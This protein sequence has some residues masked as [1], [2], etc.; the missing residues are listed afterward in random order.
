[1]GIQK[2]INLGYKGKESVNK[3]QSDWEW[4]ERE[5]EPEAKNLAVDREEEK[6]E[7]EVS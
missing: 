6:I 1:M 7:N 3:D 4:E 5:E 2:I